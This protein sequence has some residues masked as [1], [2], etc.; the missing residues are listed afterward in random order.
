MSILF[1]ILSQSLR[2][3]HQTAVIDDQ[4]EYTYGQLIG[5]A[6]F[7]ADQIDGTTDREHIGIL[8]PTSGAFP[9]A[10]LGAWLARRVVVPLN[11]MLKPDELGYVIADSD[12]DTIITIGPMLDY[13]GQQWG[14]AGSGEQA[15]IPEDM[16]RI[17]LDQLDV[18]GIPP[19]RWPPIYLDDDLAVI[20]YTS[21]TSARPKGVM[22]S[23]GNF[24]ANVD[25]AI[26]H[27][28]LTQADIFLGVLPQFHSFGLTGL[29]LLPLRIGSCVVY[30]ARFI[31]QQIVKLIKRYQPDVFMA[32]PSMYGA[33]LSVKDIELGGFASIRLAISGGE[34]LP[35]ATFEALLDQY[36]LRVYEGYGLTETAPITNWCTP[37]QNRINSVGP[38]LPGV[39][40][41]IVDDHDKLLDANQDGEILVAGKN[42]MVGYYHLP[43]KTTQVFVDLRANNRN[44][45]KLAPRYFRTGDIGHVDDDGYLYI[46]GRKKEML[47]IGGEN[48]FPREIEEVLN[49]HELVK[50]SAIIGKPDPIRGEVPLAYVE[51]KEGSHVDDTQLRAWCRQHLAGYKVPREIR[52]I[53]QLPRNSTG[54]I[55][56]RKLRSD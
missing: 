43:R 47:I 31:P 30:T 55:L 32:I 23:H 26:E 25:A 7:V 27:A 22:L 40:I 4:R 6:M 44:G 2:R 19:L 33:L 21:G 37:A 20:L 24:K 18:R 14:T 49:K 8:L 1:S 46:T 3:M 16:H 12:I 28:Q 52:H 53:D 29:T 39:D 5:G 42:V 48:V 11:Y 15:P 35:N 51:V 13:L 38:A 41:R 50:D 56:R 10:L 9:I 34:P 17:F 36:G 54:K 45:E